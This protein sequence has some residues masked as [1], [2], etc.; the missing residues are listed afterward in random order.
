MTGPVNQRACRRLVGR[1]WMT[2]ERTWLL[3][4]RRYIDTMI[5]TLFI[6]TIFTEY[7]TT[8]TVLKWNLVSYNSYS[9]F[10]STASDRK[11]SICPLTATRQLTVITYA[12]TRTET[13]MEPLKRKCS[14]RPNIHQNLTLPSIVLPL[15][16]VENLAEIAPIEV[17]C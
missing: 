4:D 8:L 5:F 15:G 2:S 10:A 17:N 6:Y 16:G 11:K 12:T 1:L 7:N 14:E 3:E 9:V 13:I